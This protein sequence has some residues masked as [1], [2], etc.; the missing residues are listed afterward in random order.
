MNASL[1]SQHAL[2]LVVFS[3]ADGVTQQEFLATVG[4]VSEWVKAQPGFI[5]RDLSY[6]EETGKYIEVVYWRSLEEA[7]SAGEAS[8]TSEACTPMFSKIRMEDMQFLHG[9]PLMQTVYA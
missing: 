6:S 3:L 8:Q 9:M 5:S 4:A 2:E 7:V 1:D